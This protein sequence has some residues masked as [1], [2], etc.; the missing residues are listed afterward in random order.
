MLSHTKKI[1]RHNEMDKINASFKEFTVIVRQTIV[2]QGF[3]WAHSHVQ[4]INEF[5]YYEFDLWGNVTFMKRF[6]S[7]LLVIN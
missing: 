6:L 2:K 5:H 3:K 1:L 4:Q 7:K